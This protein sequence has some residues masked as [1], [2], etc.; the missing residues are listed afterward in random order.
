M[1]HLDLDPDPID[2]P[3]QVLLEQVLAGAI[4]PA[5]VAQQ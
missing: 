1:R 4:A 2:Q 3:V 5:T